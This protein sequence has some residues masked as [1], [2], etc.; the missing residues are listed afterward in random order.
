MPAGLVKKRGELADLLAFLG[1]QK[2]A[3]TGPSGRLEVVGPTVYGKLPS[4][5][6]VDEYT[7]TNRGGMEVRLINYG[8]TLTSLITPDREGKRT[9]IVLGYDDL[10]GYL[11]DPISSGCIV[12]RYANRIAGARFTING[13]AFELDKNFRGGHHLHGGDVG[14]QRRL[15]EA[16]S[17][18]EPDSVGVELRYT[19]PDGEAGYPGRLKVVVRVALNQQNE[20]SFSY[21]ARTD[22]ATHVNLTQHSY[23]NLRGHDTGDVLDHRLRLYCDRYLPVDRDGLPTGQIASVAGTPFDFRQPRSIG[24]QIREVAGLYDHQVVIAG[25][26]TGVV[27]LARVS[28]PQSGRV[29]EIFTDQPGAQLYTSIH[30]SRVVGRGGTIYRKYAGLC[31]ETQHFPDSPNRPEFPST[32]LRPGEVFRSQ[33]IHRFS[34]E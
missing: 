28:E 33:T 12:G 26:P 4:G 20:L 21:Q 27:P 16:H 6:Q 31:L 2:P 34:T 24:S 18:R 10:A 8:A 19:S 32:L 13:K 30:L 5:Q 9:D 1:T 23:F 25:N 29:M 17:F 15:W 22:K 14:F 3:S 11:G 7:L